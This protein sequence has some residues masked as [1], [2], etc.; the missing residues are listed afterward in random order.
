MRLLYA[1][2]VLTLCLAA[3][4]VYFGVKTLVVARGVETENLAVQAELAQLRAERQ[5]LEAQPDTLPARFKDDAL[6]EFFSRTLEAGEVLGS[7]IRIEGTGTGSANPVFQP[8]KFGLQ[9]ASVRVTAATMA[10]DGPALL[11]MLED[12]IADLPVVIRRAIARPMDDTVSV[13]LDV[14]VFG[15]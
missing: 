3:G 14:D 8:L 9:F 1:T 15:R 12:E 6:S 13:E 4:V 7:G 5:M 2:A 11:S 10:A